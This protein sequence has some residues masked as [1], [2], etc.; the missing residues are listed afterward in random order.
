MTSPD[1]YRAPIISV[2]RHRIVL[3]GEGVNTLVIFKGCPLRC[4]YCLNAHTLSDATKCTWRTAQELYDIVRT[5]NIYFLATGGGV[6]F[7]G[8]EPSLQSAFIAE[9]RKICGNFWRIN[10]ETSLN[11]PL[12]HIQALMPIIDRW[13]IDIKDMNSDIYQSY[14]GRD[15]TQVIENL[16]WLVAQGKAD[17]IVVRVPR[18]PDFNTD[19]DVE[20]SIAM[21]RNLGLKNFDRFDYIVRNKSDKK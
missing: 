1:T 20:Q 4:R 21:L 14:T 18:I 11:V 2:A 16:Q 15:N 10:I 8:G 17:N 6:T 12:T 3:D 9:F 19:N 13:F 5:D 7:G